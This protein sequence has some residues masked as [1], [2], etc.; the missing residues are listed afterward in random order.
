[1]KRF[2]LPLS[3][4]CVTL[5]SSAAFANHI[6]LF[7]ND[8]SGDNFGFIGQ[9]N[10]HPLFLSGGTPYDFFGTGGYTPGSTFGGGTTLFLDPA[11][12]WID[13]CIRS[14]RCFRNFYYQDS[15]LRTPPT[16]S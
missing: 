9:M 7:P 14:T 1:M 13:G 8:G 6:Y 15:S 10:G 3:L 2:L 16:G 11:T 5:I 4:L 12:V